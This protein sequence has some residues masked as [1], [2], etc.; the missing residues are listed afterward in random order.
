MKK[1]FLCLA[2]FSLITTT[3]YAEF[4]IKTSI[5]KE[6]RNLQEDW[7]N[8]WRDIGVFSGQPA[9]SIHSMSWDAI[10]YLKALETMFYIEFEHQPAGAEDGLAVFQ[11]NQYIKYISSMLDIDSQYLAEEIPKINNPALANYAIK[12]Q[13]K[14]RETEK[15]IK[16][17]HD[18]LNKYIDLFKENDDTQ[19]TLNE[20]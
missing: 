17:I 16:D 4:P 18:K 8:L 1:I 13:D 10:N 2:I 7:R 15:F 5:T 20:K 3:C 6:I 14:I 11:L 19:K 9:D 12:M